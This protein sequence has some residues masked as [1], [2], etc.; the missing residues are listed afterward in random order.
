VLIFSDFTKEFDYRKRIKANR[1]LLTRTIDPTDEFLDG[2]QFIDELEPQMEKLH[3]RRTPDGKVTF[4][5]AFLIKQSDD[6]ITEVCKMLTEN[7]QEH[8]AYLLCGTPVSEK[9]HMSHE[10]HTLL[11]EKSSKL[12]Q[13]LNPIGGLLEAL[14]STDTFQDRDIGR[15]RKRNTIDDMASETITILKRKW[16]QAFD[17][18][19]AALKVTEQTH[20]IY[21]LN[22][23]G[24][25]PMT[26][27][28]LQLLRAQRKTL[29]DNILVF[30]SGLLDCL[31]TEGAFTNNDGQWVLVA[32]TLSGASARLL[33]VLMRKPASAYDKFI[34]SLLQTVQPHI[35]NELE[36][37]TI[38]GNVH[39]EYS[40]ELLG[41]DTSVA[42]TQCVNILR[43]NTQPW[44]GND[45]LITGCNGS[46]YIHFK[47]LSIQ[48]IT[49]LE[50][51]Y[52]GKMLNQQ[53]YDIFKQSF[54]N[55]GIR[56]LNIEINQSE[57]GACRT[58]FHKSEL[59]TAE[60]QKALQMAAEQL[61]DA[62]SAA[63]VLNYLELD[64]LRKQEIEKITPNDRK[65]KALLDIVA[66]LPDRSFDEL[67]TALRQS[68]QGHVASS[69][70]EFVSRFIA[71]PIGKI[72]LL[73]L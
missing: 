55:L 16:D 15:V 4:L 51:L 33:D 19:L 73:A 31:I 41:E 30:G 44:L 39:V 14:Q 3:S 68:E 72:S 65:V 52:A 59:M 61:S 10:H 50:E 12:R 27:Y 56:S 62:I 54:S 48:A 26:E 58:N 70:E 5:L 63:D 23:D 49:F 18:F 57:F 69:I 24:E 8:A 20:L 45:I 11:N 35:V 66:R 38:T 9:R 17:D 67:L 2:L 7:Y 71:E 28:Q 29:I 43:D 53:L 40:S 25:P 46:I 64:A 22:G 13:F 32:N 47:C 36:R 1:S 6:V 37:N 60:H 42:E 21:I 34:S